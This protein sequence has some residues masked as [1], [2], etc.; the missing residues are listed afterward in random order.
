MAN[1]QLALV[2]GASATAFCWFLHLLFSSS[3]KYSWTGSEWLWAAGIMVGVFQIVPLPEGMLLTISPRIKEIL[4]LWFD[5]EFTELISTKWNQLSLAPW[6]T[7]SGL[8]TFI[9]YAMLFL[10]AAQRTRTIHDIERNFYGVVFASI[11][12]MLFAQ[13]QL[14]TSNGMF[15]W[16][17]EHPFMTTEQY[18]LGCFT[19]RNHLAQFLAL[20][21]APL[22]WCLL[23][24]L[25]QQEQDR[26][27]QQAMPALV[28]FTITGLLLA[29]LGGIALTVLMTLSRG[30]FL[31]MALTCTISVG[32]MCRI[33]LASVK[34]G[35]A[36][37]LVGI[38]ASGLVSYTN[39]E[40][41]FANRLEQNSGRKDIWLANIKVA[42]DFPILGTGI[43][44][45]SDAY[46]TRFHSKED[47]GL[48]YSHAE[49]G[50]LQVASESGVAGLVVASLM[51][52]T[53]FWWCV[54]S[55][56]NADTKM[57]SAGTVVL[58]SLIENSA[59]AVVDF[60]WYTPA[61]MLLLAI[62][63]ACAAR[64]YRLTRQNAGGAARSFAVPRFMTA[65]AM[66]GLVCLT[67][68]MWDL[69]LP[70]ALAEPHRMQAI[71]LGKNDDRDFN[72]EERKESN[73]LRLKESLIAAK[74]D[75]RDSKIQE[76][77]ATAYLQLFDLKQEQ[78][79]N[80]MSA[81]ML[82][83]GIKASQFETFEASSEWLQRAV[84]AN[85]KLLHLATR[86][87]RVSLVNSPLRARSYVLLTELDFLDR[88]E[89]TSF[90][91]RCLR[92]SLKLRPREAETLYLVGK[93][94]IQEGDLEKAMTYWRPSFER[95]RLM[96]ERISDVLAS[97]MSP[98]D[99]E[100][101]F[102]PDWKALQIIAKS[103]AKA[104]RDFESIQVQ[105]MFVQQ[106]LEWARTVK[107]DKELEEPMISMANT[108]RDLGEPASAAEILSYA[109]KR[110]PHCYSIRYMLGR[111][112]ISTDR[113]ADAAE[114]LQWC[115]A[116]EPGNKALQKLATYAISKK[117]K[118]TSSSIHKD[119][120]IEQTGLFR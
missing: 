45:H 91:N 25:H 27:T 78:A 17:Y 80:S 70:A 1:G 47:D 75:P 38:V 34:F 110:L 76:A 66:C 81:S 100:K 3:P 77:A 85:L 33:G 15:F 52:A 32:L 41:I 19:N 102:H 28:H 108:C 14:M 6:E 117:L 89:D 44:T 95:S 88:L 115:V 98:E 84:G 105:R 51:I 74:L 92:Q 2:I 11:A 13:V 73:Q 118:Q 113:V 30:G 9:S 64:L 67:I 50:Y 26:A 35:L 120:S 107:V 79:E 37:L 68:W 7:A 18:P 53:G 90:Q 56:W 62:Q 31:A 119:R 116:R 57:R 58:A 23:Q 49:C 46:Q 60:F 109:V 114:H 94:K 111:D 39:Y 16:S 101:E 69:K 99:F 82:R 22:I 42:Q 87:A 71:L 21:T 36:L 8:S 54:G 20:G 86:A 61:C 93:S 43:G 96:Q 103:F 12:M 104:G 48:E 65:F 106:G 112:L 4:P 40:S 59:H 63:L 72:E 97:Q 83:D 29:G 10:V 5:K 55:L 24:R